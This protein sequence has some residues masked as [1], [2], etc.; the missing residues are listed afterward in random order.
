MSVPSVGQFTGIFRLRR[1]AVMLQSFRQTLF[2]PGGTVPRAFFFSLVPFSINPLLLV[3]YSHRVA[4]LQDCVLLSCPR[5]IFSFS[6][7]PARRLLQLTGV[8][9]SHQ[10]TGEMKMVGFIRL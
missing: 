4:K 7:S 5:S 9:T 6:K 8:Y 3:I 10:R 1:P 2:Q